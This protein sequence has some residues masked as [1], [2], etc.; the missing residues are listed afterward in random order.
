MAPD[1]LSLSEWLGGPYRD[2]TC[3]GPRRARSQHPHSPSSGLAPL[4]SVEDLVK[5]AKA[6]VVAALGAAQRGI[7]E[8]VALLPPIVHVA[9]AHDEL[10]NRGFIPIDGAN[11]RLADRVLALL[12][13][14]YLSRPNDYLPNRHPQ[15]GYDVTK[16]GMD[17]GGTNHRGSPA[18]IAG[19]SRWSNGT[20]LALACGVEGS[21]ARNRFSFRRCPHDS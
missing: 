21:I 18:G 6:A 17:A 4:T 2:A 9:P 12:V 15:W 16:A 19:G 14:D 20:K 10:G 5:T 7:D 3:F 1:D 8:L 13:A 11:M